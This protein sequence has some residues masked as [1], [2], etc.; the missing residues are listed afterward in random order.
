MHRFWGDH[1]VDLSAISGGF[2]MVGLQ[3][4]WASSRESRRQL[5]KTSTWSSTEDGRMERFA[6]E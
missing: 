1:D 2:L 6:S 5:I 3:K 4:L